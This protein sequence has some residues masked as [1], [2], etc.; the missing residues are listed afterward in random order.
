MLIC[1]DVPLFTWSS[2][3]VLAVCVACKS[4]QYR[5]PRYR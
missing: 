2:W 5:K 1:F 3:H 4:G